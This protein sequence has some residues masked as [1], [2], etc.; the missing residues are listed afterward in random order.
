MTA[1]ESDEYQKIV[2]KAQLAVEQQEIG[3]ALEL[4]NQAYEMQQTPTLNHL[5]TQ[6]LLSDGQNQL[7]H[8]L[9]DEFIDSYTE[10]KVLAEQYVE[11]ALKNHHYLI[12]REFALA[13]KWQL[14]LCEKINQQEQADRELYAQTLQTTAKHF[15]HLSDGD[16]IQ[17]QTR[18]TAAEHLPLADY[19]TGA[20]FV[21]VDPFL[22][23]ITRVT[24]LDRLRRLQVDQ[25]VKM[26]W[27][28]G[29]ELIVVPKSLLAIEEM[30][31][32][33]QLMAILDT[34][35]MQV[36]GATL[37]AIKAGLRLNMLVAYPQLNQVVQSPTDWIKAM[38]AEAKGETLSNESTAQR[39]IRQKLHQIILELMP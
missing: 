2:D 33:Q 19:V 3:R 37:A 14:A 38:L 13:T 29:S 5:L 17:Q 30:P 9:A 27:F 31:I 28:D 36:D 21:L 18:L 11:I 35:D 25:E 34:N 7:A 22:T 20:R 24:V 26:L 10:K 8:T 1:F 23:P 16:L 32:Y 15:Y 39:Q 12:A 6:I 4:L